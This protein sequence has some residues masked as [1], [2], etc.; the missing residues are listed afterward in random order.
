MHN[1]LATVIFNNRKQGEKVCTGGPFSTKNVTPES[2]C[3]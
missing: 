2:S 3:K 1:H